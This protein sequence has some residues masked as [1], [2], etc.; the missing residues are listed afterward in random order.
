MHLSM[1]ITRLSIMEQ[2]LRLKEVIICIKLE[3][4]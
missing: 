4:V 3:V 1:A 2:A